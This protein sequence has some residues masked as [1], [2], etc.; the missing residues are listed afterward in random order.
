MTQTLFHDSH[1]FV[2]LFIALFVSLV[3]FLV[4]MIIAI[5][6]ALP[7]FHLNIFELQDIFSDFENVSNVRVLKYFQI[8][9]TLGLFVVRPFVIVFLFYREVG[10][11]LQLKNL[12]ELQVSVKV[13]LIMIIGMPAINL[14]AMWNAGI[15]LPQWLNSVEQWMKVTEESAEK[16]TEMFL[17][18][19]NAGEFLI[20]FLMI[21][22]L[23]AIGEELLF[24]GLIQRY[25]IEWLKNKHI[26][27]LITSI[28]FSALHLQ[29]FGFFP[30]LLLGVFFGYLLLWS[31]NL[32]LPILAHFINNGVAVIF[33]FVFGAE[34][35]E[36]EIDSI[37]TESG[38]LFLAIG[39]LVLVTLL[40]VSVYKEEGNKGGRGNR[41]IK[42][43]IGTFEQTCL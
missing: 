19:D 21:A 25:L 29:F 27:V 14:L 41:G 3:I 6:V 10:E 18:A 28:L 43:N 11:S 26:S 16:L 31:R 36:N 39:S 32:W 22:I 15:D 7:V 9:Q 12:P 23:P 17:S 35:V 13:F 24:R 40:V 30:R 37:G 42:G 34:I 38:T 33:Y 4:F 8:I 1:P 20:N 2:K 5:I